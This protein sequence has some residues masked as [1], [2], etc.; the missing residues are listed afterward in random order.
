M[1]THSLAGSA[2][3][4]SACAP[5]LSSFT[6]AHVA[7]AG[8]IQLELGTDVSIPSSG[9]DQLVNAGR[10]LE[11]NSASQQL[12][13]KQQQDLL[14]AG[15]ALIL[16]PPA[17]IF[18]T[19]LAVGVVEDWE[20]SGR[21]VSGG[22]HLGG[23][24][25]FLHEARDGIDLSAGVGFGANRIK[26]SDIS[27]FEQLSFD[28]YVRWHV[29]LPLLV[30]KSG[31][32]YRWWA[33]PRLVLSTYHTGMQLTLPPSEGNPGTQFSTSLDGHS[34]HAGGQ[35]GGALGY[36]WLFLAFELTVTYVGATA[37][38]DSTSSEL[39]KFK[40]STS[41]NVVYPALGLMG[42]F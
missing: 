41:G 22:W 21:L 9:F 26:L 18:H 34:L 28:D 4:L 1:A 40:T 5:A 2:L 38:L 31:T 24:H 35:A 12:T 7:R 17:V 25:Q 37:N 11:Q 10:Q 14:S 36:K 32:W 29:D 27:P 33:G 19:G 30:G 16:N 15:W 20:V 42:E 3:I 13:A 23:R 39:G 6:P 8:H